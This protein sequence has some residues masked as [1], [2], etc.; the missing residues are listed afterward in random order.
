MK[1]IALFLLSIFMLAGCDQADV[2]DDSSSKDISPEELY[3]DFI[4]ERI[5]AVGK[6][7]SDITLKDCM[8]NDP[9]AAYKEYA[10]Y[11]MNGDEVP[12]LIVK[13][14]YEFN[15]FWVDDNQLTLWYHG[16]NYTK[17]L[18]NMALLSE[19]P[20]GAPTHTDYIYIVLDYRGEEMFRLD[21]GEYSAVEIDGVQYDES[22]FINSVQVSEEVYDALTEPLLS[23]SDDKITW[24][25]LP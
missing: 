13:T 12:E 23:V 25:D 8:R 7:G 4:S 5:N 21:F 22:Y 1:K 24:N 18:N 17:P 20:G 16:T 10:I 19:R 6:D 9:N 11:D 15:I 14:S 2:N 3:Q